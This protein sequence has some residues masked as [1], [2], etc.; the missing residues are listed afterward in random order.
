[1]VE[2]NNSSSNPGVALISPSESPASRPCVLVVEDHEDTREMLRTILEMQNFAVLEA[3]DGQAGFQLAVDEQPDLV[4]MD[5]TLPRVDGVEATK[6]IRNHAGISEVP[7]IFL[8]ARAEPAGKTA[9]FAAGCNDYL[10]KPLKLDDVLLKVQRWL[11][12]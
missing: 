9:A 2:R 5:L 6:A 4:L 8:S 10:T 11:G 7:I 12:G 3:A 1:M